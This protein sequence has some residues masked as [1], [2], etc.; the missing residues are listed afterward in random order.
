[1]ESRSRWVMHWSEVS[2]FDANASSMG[3]DES[4]LMRAAGDGLA[5]AAARMAGGKPVL[6]L[7]GPGNNGGDGFA[8][9]CSEALSGSINTVV[10]SHPHSKSGA[11]A[12]FRKAAE[13]RLGAHVWPSV[14]DG[15]W[16][17]VVDC[18][19]GAGGSGP[20]SALR[21]PISEI[22]E[23]AGSLGAP[24]LA[25]DIPSGLGGPDCLVADRTITFHSTKAGMGSEECGEIIVFDLPWPEEV[26]DCGI[27]D[28]TRLPPIG[29]EARKGDRGRVLVI[30]GGPYHGAPILAGMA[31]ARSGCDLVHVAMP[32]EASERARWPPSL[33]PEPLPDSDRISARSASAVSGILDSGR[34]PGAIVLGPG[35]GREEESISAAAEIIS[36]SA[37]RCIPVV[38]DAEAISALPECRWPDGLLGVATPHDR[39]ADRWLSGT[40]PSDALSE[41]S[42]EGSSIVVT[43]PSDEITG[44][45]GRHCYATGGNPRMAV[46]GSGDLLAGTIGGL[47]AQGMPAW[48]ASR[49]GCALLREAGARAAKT[50]GPGLL[51]EDVPVHIA[52]ALSDWTGGP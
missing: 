32:S 48:P 49:L 2:V 3:I 52:H 19:L 9:S 34:P 43:G 18:L 13:E 22:A 39:E 26:Q 50:K 10:A 29:I 1:M 5:E 7:C 6:F 36:A 37:S 33:I 41:Q 12:S 15:E 11:A 16:G 24:V 30:G 45:Q 23:W 4:E 44:A 51:A 31:A 14:P 35:L 21:P 20:G 28:A 27:G 46:G 17:L 38:V 8:A 42:G 25:C 40:T 47:L